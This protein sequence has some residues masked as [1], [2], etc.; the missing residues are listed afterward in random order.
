MLPSVLL[1]AT[2]AGQA[3]LASHYCGQ[4]EFL[5]KGTKCTGPCLGRKGETEPLWLQSDTMSRE[6]GEEWDPPE[7]GEAEALGEVLSRM[8]GAFSGDKHHL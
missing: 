5:K 7:S 3:P 6:G 1:E 4:Q 8:T 2:S